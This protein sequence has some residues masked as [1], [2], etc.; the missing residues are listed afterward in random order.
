[1]YTNNN[2]SY[3]YK[4][5]AKKQNEVRIIYEK[6]VAKDEDKMAKQICLD[7]YPNLWGIS[8]SST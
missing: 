8:F 1:M 7:K 2:N 5:S 4:Y 3:T 6:Y